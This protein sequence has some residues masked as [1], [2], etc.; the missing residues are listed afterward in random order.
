MRKDLLLA[1]IQIQ[2][3]RIDL[4][5]FRCCLTVLE[6]GTTYLGLLN[7]I[8]VKNEKEKSLFCGLRAAAG[9]NNS[10]N[11]DTIWRKMEGCKI[12]NRLEKS[13]EEQQQYERLRGSYEVQE[14]RSAA[15]EF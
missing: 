1:L 14:Y 2:G 8:D 6:K 3:S 7:F 4:Q 11:K 13:A 10:E 5:H 9:G 12:R 15:Y